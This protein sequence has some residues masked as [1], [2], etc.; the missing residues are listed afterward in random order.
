MLSYFQ[1]GCN[2]SYVGSRTN[3]DLEGTDRG[4]GGGVAET[5]LRL[6]EEY[7]RS[8]EFFSQYRSSTLEALRSDPKLMKSLT[9]HAVRV[10]QVVEKVVARMDSTNKVP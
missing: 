6:F 9:E 4:L 8:Q 10:L 5:F 7:P 1:M 3:S 2:L